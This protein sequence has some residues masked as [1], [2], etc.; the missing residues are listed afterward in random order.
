MLREFEIPDEV[1]RQVGGF[2]IVASHKDTLNNPRMQMQSGDEVLLGPLLT[3]G[4]TETLIPA[5]TAFYV[6]TMSDKHP[7]AIGLARIEDD[8]YSGRFNPLFGL[9][10][11]GKTLAPNLY[12]RALKGFQ[13]M[14]APRKA[15]IN[16]LKGLPPQVLAAAESEIG[17]AMKVLTN[18]GNM[19]RNLLAAYSDPAQREDA[20]LMLDVLLASGSTLPAKLLSDLFK[21]RLIDRWGRKAGDD[22]G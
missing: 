10:P 14:L 20:N 17:P 12:E 11:E 22:V 9:D 16:W 3:A 21:L 8:S 2:Y 19:I 15:D 13:G 1:H 4:E 6:A 5:V 18:H 7:F